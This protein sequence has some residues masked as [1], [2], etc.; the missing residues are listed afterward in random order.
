MFSIRTHDAWGVVPVGEFA[1][2]DAAR[3]AFGELCRDPWYR[4][5][6]TVRGIEL[7]DSRPEAGDRRLEWF[8]FR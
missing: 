5:D 1:S 2:L 3:Q 7:I 4:D 8:A 6:G